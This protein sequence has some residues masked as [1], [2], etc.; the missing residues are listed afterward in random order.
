MRHLLFI[1][2]SAAL[3]CV[4]ILGAGISVQAAESQT[5][6]MKVTF[7][8][9]G[10]GDCILIETGGQTVLIDAGY[11]ETAGDVISYLQDSGIERLDYMIIT[12]YDKD[13][14][15]GASDIATSFDIGQIYLPDYE[16]VSKYYI[17]FKST[18]GLH[19]L[20]ASR[21]SEAL[22]FQ[23]SDAEFTIYPSG[24]SY[25]HET[26][27]KEEG[28]DNDMSL[29]ISLY[30][31]DDSYM[32][33]GDLEEEGV[34]NY[35]AAD[36]GQFDVLKVPHHGIKEGNTEDFI[37]DVQPKIAIITDGDK[38]KA[39]KK[40]VKKLKKADSECY[41]SSECGTIIITGNGTGNYEVTTEK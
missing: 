32:F 16:G 6:D 36:H 10:K 34:D 24:V 15:G 26:T 29:V 13:H 4:I 28:N 21:V 12:H 2:T 11:A 22:S 33:A 17:A 41:Q 27:G 8:D 30:Y 14:V 7:I 39:D 38:D 25:T 20:N 3:M 5:D 23:I 1:F 40:V 9:V 18:I 35:L 19:G 37:A 31:G